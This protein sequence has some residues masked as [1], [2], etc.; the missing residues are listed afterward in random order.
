[1]A[2]DLTNEIKFQI[3]EFTWDKLDKVSVASTYHKLK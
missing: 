1:M 3:G 2:K